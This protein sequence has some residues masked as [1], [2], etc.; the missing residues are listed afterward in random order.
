LDAALRSSSSGAVGPSSQ[1]RKHKQ[2][3]IEGMYQDIKLRNVRK[4]RP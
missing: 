4:S 1:G 3:V 2:K